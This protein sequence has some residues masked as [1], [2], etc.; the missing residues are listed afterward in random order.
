MG[1]QILCVL[2]ALIILEVCLFLCFLKWLVFMCF[3]L[4]PHANTVFGLKVTFGKCLPL[5]H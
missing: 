1:S 5:F 4:R 3:G 2:F